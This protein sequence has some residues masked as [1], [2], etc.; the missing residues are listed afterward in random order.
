MSTAPSSPPSA[1]ASAER[2]RR[3]VATAIAVFLVALGARLTFYAARGPF[4]TL[5]G[6]E[7]ARLAHNLRTQGV[8]SLSTSMTG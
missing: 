4:V 8:Y 6:I 3:L 5:D 7:Y 1:S 2:R